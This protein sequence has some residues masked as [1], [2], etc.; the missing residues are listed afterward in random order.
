MLATAATDL[1]QTSTIETIAGGET[2]NREF[3][4]FPVS[5]LAADSRGNIY[6]SI[7]A[8]SQVTAGLSGDGGPA[9]CAQLNRPSG[10]SFDEQKNLYI[11]DTGNQRVRRVRM[12]VQTARCRPGEPSHPEHAGPKQPKLIRGIGHHEKE[13]WEKP[14]D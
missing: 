4:V 14:G 10:I 5:G 6:F 8:M 1:R 2:T 7:Q 3:G 12:G 9:E 11:A 13:D